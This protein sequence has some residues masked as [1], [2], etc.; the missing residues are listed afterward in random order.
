MVFLMTW[1]TDDICIRG[2]YVVVS[3]RCV[4]R[5]VKIHQQRFVR[6]LPRQKVIVDGEGLILTPGLIDLQINGF[7]GYEFSDGDS[8]VAFAQSQFPAFGITSFLPTMGCQPLEKYRPTALRTVVEKAKMRLGADV[9][10]WHLEG[11]FLN[12]HQCGIHRISYILDHLDEPFWKELFATRAIALMTLAPEMPFA[13]K[14]LD[15]LAEAGVSSAIGHSLADEE[16]LMMAQKKG[17]RFVTHLFNAMLPFHHRS[18]GILGA[19]L[20][21]ELLGFSLICDLHHVYP[22]AVNIAFK[23][24]PHGLVLVSDGAPLMGSKEKSGMFLGNPVEIHGEKVLISSGGGLAGS[25]IS[26]DEQL[27]R[28]MV[29]TGCAFETAVQAVTEI[30]ASFLPV[31]HKKGKIA[32]GYD[33]DCVF[34]ESSH[35]G[36]QVMATVCRGELAYSRKDFGS[37]VTYHG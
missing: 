25:C 27:R 20:G 36:M 10:G 16:D 12:P 21:K 5:D 33:A 4:L 13:G 35:M 30:P 19:V 29:V 2:A 17:A 37:R 18:P 15:L 1:P 3:G 9:L 22:E 14:L 6:N 7:G 32:I 26:L 11:P 28:F 23:C 34:W 24:H 8:S 31:A